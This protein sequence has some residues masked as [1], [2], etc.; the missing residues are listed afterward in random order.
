MIS[1]E[2]LAAGRATLLA[3]NSTRVPTGNLCFN[4]HLHDSN[5]AG[6]AQGPTATDRLKTR[7]DI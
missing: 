5:S 2:P 4:A 3:V 6:C 1:Y 7:R